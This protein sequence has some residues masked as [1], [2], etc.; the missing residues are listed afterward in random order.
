MKEFTVWVAKGCLTIVIGSTVL[1]SPITVLAQSSPPRARLLTPTAEGPPA[2]TIAPVQAGVSIDQLIAMVLNS[3]P[4]LRVGYEEINLAVSEAITAS[5]RPNPTFSTDGQLL[6]LTRSFTPLQQGGPPQFDALISYPIDWFLFGK[7]KAAMASSGIGIRQ[8]ESEYYDLVRLRIQEASNLYYDILELRELRE[9]ARQDLESL[10]KVEGIFK[11]AVAGGGRPEVD[12]KGIMT[13]RLRSEQFLRDA[14]LSN[15]KAKTRLRAIVGRGGD[16]DFD[17]AG[18][19]DLPGPVTLPSVEEALAIAQAN[20]PDLEA[21]RYKVARAE[22]DTVVEK[23]K[24]FPTVATKAGYSRQFQGSI[25]FRDADTYLIGV[26]LSLPLFDRN[27]GNRA[28]AA[29]LVAQSKY[30]LDLSAVELRSEIDQ[31]L[32]EFRNAQVS[33]E[34]VARDQLKVAEEFRDSILKAN[35]VGGRPL[36][37]VLDAQRRYRETYRLYITSR[38]NYWRASVRLN[39]TLG[40]KVVP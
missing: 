7:R 21:L 33:A 35:V 23:R 14:V 36:V 13:D 2:R 31:T 12:L 1:D 18:S 16:G 32:F 11:Q 20:R 3:D 27:Q 29:T 28:R 30:E 26:D 24:A 9:L 8:T 22:A 25:G 4:K 19:L 37:D 10:Q 17:V 34:A 39:A 6:P 38:A 40:K 5:L 15:N